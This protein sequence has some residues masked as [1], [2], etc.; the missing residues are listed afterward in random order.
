M[1]QQIDRWFGR[2][3]LVLAILGLGI[4]TLGMGAGWMNGEQGVTVITT[5][6]LMFGGGNVMEHT[7]NALRTYFQNRNKDG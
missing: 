4:A 1:T 7:M 3:K 6:I 5:S 2:R